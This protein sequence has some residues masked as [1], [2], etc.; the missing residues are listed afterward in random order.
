MCNSIRKK[1]ILYL[2]EKTF[3]TEYFMGMPVLYHLREKPEVVTLPG[4]QLSSRKIM[5]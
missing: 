5:S 1:R 2:T 4:I 3:M